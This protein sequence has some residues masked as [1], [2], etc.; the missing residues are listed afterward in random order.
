M[1]KW[2]TIWTCAV[3]EESILHTL[4]RGMQH[5]DLIYYWRDLWSILF[6]YFKPFVKYSLYSFQ[7]TSSLYSK[8]RAVQ[9]SM[10]HMPCICHAHAS[11]YLSTHF[12][13]AVRAERRSPIYFFLAHFDWY[14]YLKFKRL[15]VIYDQHVVM[16]YKWCWRLHFIKY[17]LIY[18]IFI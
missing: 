6:I 3:V 9:S 11:F 10:W 12:M 15:Y 13:C 14:L 1:R 16:V 5:T 2:N 7:A 4:S 17:D 18:R 8:W